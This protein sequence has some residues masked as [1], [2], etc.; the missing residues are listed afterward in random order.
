MDS[1][2]NYLQASRF[3]FRSMENVLIVLGKRTF[4]LEKQIFV[5]KLVTWVA[6]SIAVVGSMRSI[7]M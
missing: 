2:L 7:R 5:P 1:G 6:S 4:Y 3:A